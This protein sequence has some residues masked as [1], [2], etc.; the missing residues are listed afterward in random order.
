MAIVKNI[1]Y[2]YDLSGANVTNLVTVDGESISPVLGI[3]ANTSNVFRIRVITPLD[4]TLTKDISFLLNNGRTVTKSDINNGGTLSVTYQG[5]TDDWNVYYYDLTETVLGLVALLTSSPFDYSMRFREENTLYIGAYDTSAELP[6]IADDPTLVDGNY[7]TVGTT[8]FTS[9]EYD[10]DLD[11]WSD[12]GF[13]KD[14]YVQTIPTENVRLDVYYTPQSTSVDIEQSE[15]DIIRQWLQDLENE[16]DTILVALKQQD[17]DGN[18]EPTND[19]AWSSDKRVYQYLA[20]VY[21]TLGL[22]FTIGALT[23]DSVSTPLFTLENDNGNVVATV[24]DDGVVNFAYPSGVNYEQG[25]NLYV[26]VKASVPITDGDVVQ[27]DQSVGASGKIEG[28][29]AVQSEINIEPR[30]ILGMATE[31]IAQNDIGRINF[32]GAVSSLDTSAYSEKDLIYFDSEGSTPGAITNVEPTAPYV[33]VL[34]GAVKVSNPSN[35][36]ISVRPDFGRKVGQLHDVSNTSKEEN[37]I[38]IVNANDVYVN[39]S[40]D[41]IKL[42]KNGWKIDVVNDVSTFEF[43]PTT[44]IFTLELDTDNDYYINNVKYTLLAN[45]PKTV[46]LSTIIG[47]NG[48]GNYYV[49]MGTSGELQVSTSV[50]DLRNPQS[51]IVAEI[52]WNDTQQLCINCAFEMHDYEYA[53]TKHY[54]DHFTIGTRVVN[55]LAVSQT[56]GAE[57]VDVTQGK[58]MDEGIVIQILDGTSGLFTQSLTALETYKYYRLGTNELYKSQLDTSVVYSVGGIPQLNPF[59]GSTYSL[60]DMSNNKFGAYW[61][62]YTT[63]VNNPVTLWLGQNESDTLNDA[64]EDNGLSSMNFTG[65]PIEEI[66][67]AYRIMIQRNGLGYTIEQIDNFLVDPETGTPINAPTS[68]GSLSGLLDDDH[69]QYVLKTL[70]SYTDVTGAGATGNEEVYLNDAGTPKK[71]TLDEVATFANTATGAFVSS[72]DYSADGL[73]SYKSPMSTILV[74]SLVSNSDFKVNVKTQESNQVFYMRFPVHTDTSNLRV[75]TDDGV[76]YLSALFPNTETNIKGNQVSELTLRFEYDGT[77]LY[78]YI[79][80]IPLE[81]SSIPYIGTQGSYEDDPKNGVGITIGEKTI[82]IPD[83]YKGRTISQLVTNGNFADGITGWSPSGSTLTTI[84]NNLIITGNGVNQF[85]TAFQSVVTIGSQ[86]YVQ[87]RARVTNSLCNSIRIWCGGAFTEQTNP[88]QNEWYEFSSLLT[89]V[90]NTNIELN[91]RYDNTTDA[92]G[93]V[94]EVDYVITIPLPSD[95]TTAEEMSKYINGYIE[96]GVHNVKEV[97]LQSI[98]KNKFNQYGDILLDQNINSSGIPQASV[99]SFM[100]EYYIRVIPNVDYIWHSDT[101]GNLRLAQYDS[102]F[103]FL[104]LTSVTSTALTTQLVADASYVRVSGS[105]L[106]NIDVYQL[107]LGTT[108]T[109]YEEYKELES[110]LECELCGIGGVYDDLYTQRFGIDRND[111]VKSATSWSSLFELTNTKVYT[112]DF[113]SSLGYKV[114]SNN[115]TVVNISLKIG[116]DIYNVTDPTSQS[117]DDTEGSVSLFTGSTGLGIR[118]NKTTYPTSADFEAYLQANDVEFIYELD[119]YLPRTEAN[120]NLSVWQGDVMTDEGYTFIHS[121]SSNVLGEFLVTSAINTKKQIDKNTQTLVNNSKEIKALQSDVDIINTN[122]DSIETSIT[123]IEDDVTALD[124]RVGDNETNITG[125]DGRVTTNEDDIATVYKWT[126]VSINDVNIPTS[127]AS[128]TLDT[129]TVG[130]EVMEIV[131]HRGDNTRRK[132]SYVAI[133]SSD[134]SIDFDYV[135]KCYSSTITARWSITSSG[136]T[137]I[138]IGNAVNRTVTLS[139]T[140]STIQDSSENTYDIISIRLGK[141]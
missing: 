129:S 119:E 95:I 27:F 30:L 78:G 49:T 100:T 94:M 141:L 41:N 67:V 114:P 88:T 82:G 37:D 62:V 127:T 123:S 9:Y 34:I 28:K 63:D 61:V 42:L 5:L 7:A 32:Y 76:T 99:G 77:T 80:D 102:E 53:N 111:V 15:V 56:S 58:L 105:D 125:L 48:S 75:S 104:K 79:T 134:G 110:T 126:D 51:A 132:I 128:R 87:A 135:E 60:V 71:M 140:A 35:G 81:N 121:S 84:D 10:A 137:S 25:E 133:D 17:V 124:T 13:T 39:Y 113:S 29:P 85:P 21:N 136:G 6:L 69:T 112:K 131:W 93:A 83:N 38:L 19:D 86:Y 65:I 57:T 139:P 31:D 26:R 23:A 106:T 18:F 138:T 122:I 73:G 20:N 107:E 2:F 116:D 90:S 91:H 16:I 92:N 1:D 117:T 66:R 40:I 89:A 33:Q 74:P 52:Y 101:S 97:T 44:K 22:D 120:N 4:T 14:P 45:T 8:T 59:N 3:N 46:D 98:A 72:A 70:S 109:D 115:S 36:Q 68:H 118:V 96:Q 54:H 11:S 24:G 43:N 50:W 103:N 130:Y 55:G 47:T 108:A 12:L 64:I